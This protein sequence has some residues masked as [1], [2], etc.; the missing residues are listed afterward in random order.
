MTLQPTPTLGAARSPA[1]AA[2]AA[3]QAGAAGTAWRQ[4]YLAVLTWAFTLFSSVRVVSYLPTLWAIGASGDS[5]QH[6]LWTWGI[7]LGSNVT[8]ALW[9]Y[10]QHGQR[11]TRA[12]LVNSVNAA[13]CAATFTVIAVFRF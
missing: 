10:E 12:A 5:S 9:L 11:W 6:S 8:M 3:P 4:R 13:M 1:L 7:W 2:P